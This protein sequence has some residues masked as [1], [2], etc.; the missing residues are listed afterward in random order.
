L[1]SVSQLRYQTNPTN[2]TMMEDKPVKQLL[3]D[4]IQ[5]ISVCIA[6]AILAALFVALPLSAQVSGSGSIEGT[7][8]DTSGSVVPGATVTC[9]STAT[10]ISVVKT[11]TSA[12]FYVVSPLNPGDYT[13]E[14]KAQGFGTVRQE[15]I[16]VQPIEVTGLNM[17]LK[18]GATT[19]Q[20]TV[21]SAP[22][23]IDTVNGTLDTV[24]PASAYESL[25]VS[26]AGGP[27]SPLAFTNNLPTAHTDN[28]YGTY[29][30][31]GGGMGTSIIYLNGLPVTDA[32]IGGD[33]SPLVGAT[34]TEIVSESQVITSGIPASYSGTGV[35][36][37]VSKSGSDRFHGDV[38]ENVRNTVFDSAPYNAGGKVPLEQQNEYGFS[39]GGPVI[40]R[41]LFFFFNLDRYKLNAGS[42]P[43]LVTI[44]TAAEAA[45]DFSAFGVNI[46]DPLTTSCTSPGVCTRQQFSYNGKLNVIPPS[47]ISNISKVFEAP[48]PAPSNSGL[49]NNY[50]SVFANGSRQKMYDAKVDWAVNQNHHVSFLMENGSGQPAE[51]SGGGGLPLPF[52]GSLIYP[53]PTIWIGQIGETWTLKSTLVNVLSL[54]YNRFSH[55]GVSQTASGKW[56][57]KAGLKGIPAG[58]SADAFPSVVF[59]GGV[60]APQEWGTVNNLP[61]TD[62]ENMYAYQDNVQWTKGKHSFTFGGQLGNQQANNGTSNGVYDIYFVNTETSDILPGGTP[63]ST[64]GSAYASYLIGAVDNTRLV[65]S[66]FTD[67]GMRYRQWAFWAQDDWKLTHKLTLNIGLRY[68]LMYPN[69]EVENRQSWVNVDLPNPAV[70]GHLGALQFAGSGTDGCKCRNL[71]EMHHLDFDPRVGFAYGINAKTVVRAAYGITHFPSGTVGPNGILIGSDAIGFLAFPQWQSPDSGATPAFYWDNGY[72]SYVHP[73][74]FDP[75]FE[76][77][78]YT[79]V[80]ATGSSPFVTFPKTAGRPPYAEMWNFTVER[81]LVPSLVW[82]LSY[83]GSASHLIEVWGGG[84]ALGNTLNPAYF[85]LGGLL[86][87]AETPATLAAAQAIV[88]GISL[89]YPNFVGSIGQML[90]P[91]P[92]Y[93]PFNTFG[94]TNFGS[95]IYHSMMTTISKKMGNG[96]F[97]QGSYVWSKNLGI[98]GGAVEWV[99]SVL[100]NNYN[101]SID[102]SYLTED[103]PNAIKFAFVYDLPAGRGHKIGGGNDLED[104][105]LGNW[106]VSGL[107]N[108][109]DGSPIGGGF[110]GPGT[111]GGG[112]T[113]SN[114]YIPSIAT[115]D[116]A[117]LVGAFADY[118][119]NF[120]GNARIGGK[121]SI[122]NGPGPYLNA[123]AFKDPAPLT[124]GNTPRYM[125]FKGFRNPWSNDEDLDLSKEFKLLEGANLRLQVDAFNVFNRTLLGG[126]DTNID[127]SSFGLVSGQRNGPRQ[128]QFEAYVRF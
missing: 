65:D 75:T 8:T 94:Y 107:I 71:V 44:P 54:Q 87:Q 127:D 33:Q 122:G 48:L 14:F 26:M 7:V 96:L 38:Y 126:I 128:L 67:Y 64:N 114:G 113:S 23:A 79:T 13:V 80:G 37:V 24:L 60:D 112:I 72:P 90:L 47:R 97:L 34:S 109:T 76:T 31:G 117:G 20:I 50:S 28:N 1:Q 78:Y 39:V 51:V 85:K 30:L 32:Q 66:T 6:L 77:G 59:A 84:G 115:T 86:A 116:G 95:Q 123:A 125:A 62:G 57:S 41:H 55:P 68:N 27:K 91:Y 12:G 2:R 82:N 119:P 40:K 56:A 103:F 25:P 83:Q 22:P 92:Q 3:R 36:N 21:T 9:T 111:G 70:N 118:N 110:A 98:G 69:W 105:L 11:T 81:E 121:I 89:P 17:T 74:F 43:Q 93:G 102:R 10:G 108:Y 104:V 52:G 29:Y 16:M 53:P 73:P 100:R 124:F 45:G 120:H 106:R 5:R 15:H 99:T 88:P 61:S 19:E 18:V 63:D 49:S 101:P 4:K 46:Y 35:I 42:T 58:T